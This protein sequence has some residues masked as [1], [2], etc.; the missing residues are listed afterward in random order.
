MV[1]S[2]QNLKFSL[3]I[4][5]FV[6][7]Y[8]I[9]TTLLPNISI[10]C[11]CNRTFRFLYEIGKLVFEK[12]FHISCFY[13]LLSQRFLYLMTVK[14]PSVRNNLLEEMNTQWDCIVWKNT[15]FQ[16]IFIGNRKEEYRIF[17]MVKEYGRHEVS[18]IQVLIFD[19][20][21]VV[22]FLTSIFIF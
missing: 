15:C 17:S 22:V 10:L 6:W 12:K 5:T 4:W 16:Q 13:Y 9:K 19:S 1:F 8:D 11:C 20:V 14:L 2:V 21:D 7:T 18:S 3:L